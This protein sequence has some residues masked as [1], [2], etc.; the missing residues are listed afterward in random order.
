MSDYPNSSDP[1]LETS[2]REEGVISVIVCAALFGALAWLA[3]L[4]CN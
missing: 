3:S 2:A 1:K 4:P